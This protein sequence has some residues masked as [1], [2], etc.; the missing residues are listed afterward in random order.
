MVCSIPILEKTCELPPAAL[1]QI[2][3]YV[4][5]EVQTVPAPVGCSLV[6]TALPTMKSG[7]I[8]VVVPFDNFTAS[9]SQ[10]IG[11]DRPGDFYQHEI[12]FEIRKNRRA[13]AEWLLRL[14][15]RRI[16]ILFEDWSGV[17]MWLPSMRVA[18]EQSIGASLG[19]KNTYAFSLSSRTLTPPIYVELPA[20]PAS[21]I[22]VMIVGSTFQIG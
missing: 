1:R 15:N 9:Y 2:Q 10:K 16:H 12:K 14:R 6:V 22:G 7:K 13:V 5:D 17:K 18:V 21:G 8:P 11:G 19:D 20:P 4:P 3:F